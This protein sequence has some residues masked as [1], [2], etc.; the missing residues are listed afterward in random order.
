MKGKDYRNL[1][2]KAYRRQYQAG[3]QKDYNDADIKNSDDADHIYY[4]LNLTNQ[5]KPNNNLV[6]A[7]FNETRS[8]AIL[9]NPAEY[10][11]SIIR[12][13]LSKVNIPIFYM[14]IFPEYAASPFFDWIS[15]DTYILNQGTKFNGQTYIS[16]LALNVGNQPDIS[17]LAWR[18]VPFTSQLWNNTVIYSINQGVTYNNIIYVS[19]VNGN[20][21][22]QPNTSPAQW[23]ITQVPPILDNICFNLS[24][25]AVSMAYNVQQR[26]EYIV[27]ETVNPDTLVFPQNWTVSDANNANYYGVFIFS[28][29]IDMINKAL[30][31]CYNGMDPTSPPKVAG[32]PAPYL[33]L[34]STTL[35]IS[36]VA[37]KSFDEHPN[38]TDTIKIYFN[39]PLMSFFRDSLQYT[40]F[41]DDSFETPFD[42]QL[43]VQSRG[44]NTQTL[45]FPDINYP[46]WQSTLNYAV[47]DGV[48]F[49]GTNL[50]Y[51]A[52]AISF[53]QEPDISPG[54]WTVQPQ[55]PLP[56]TYTKTGVYAIGDVVEYLGFYYRNTTGANTAPPNG[57]DWDSYTGFDMLVMRGDY[58]SLYNWV[59]IQSIL[60]VTE[61]VPIVDEFVPAGRVNP[62]TT[63]GTLSTSNPTLQ[64]IS[65]F[66]PEIQTGS[67]VNSNIVFFNQGEYRLAN[68]VSDTPLRSIKIQIY[69][70]DRYNQLYPLY[71]Q[72][73]GVASCKILFRKKSIKGGLTYQK[74]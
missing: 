57:I 35:I 70:T 67:D 16:L 8:T 46:E 15:T 13:S 39:T 14:N 3:P 33:L 47:G 2:N 28:Q 42:F 19:L 52:T 32:A 49:E 43:T 21:G 59:D 54:F 63:L 34:D 45:L 10:T 44:D 30:K 36:L 56:Q 71:I 37:H 68:M 26:T 27:Y 64:I 55:Q 60:F 53:N 9:D 48:F 74:Y 72:P 40:V 73:Y 23:A 18:F 24:Q 20:V 51:V 4:N 50:N 6:L 61:L 1:D 38:A 66:I 17:P 41:H 12:F 65:D 7:N 25:Y 22:N 29:F 5:N 31:S 69:Y 11:M 62:N 58:A